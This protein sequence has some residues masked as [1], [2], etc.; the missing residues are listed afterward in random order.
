MLLFIRNA[1]IHTMDDH[2][3]LAS[4]ALVEDGRFVFVGSERGAQVELARRGPADETVDMEGRLV[5]PGFNDSH[6][7]FIHFA[8]S[9]RSVS[10]TGVC[11]IQEIQ[12]RMAQAVAARDPQNPT[13]LEGEGWNQ[14]YFT[15]GE[16][17]FPTR[18]DLDAVSPDVPMMIMRACFHIGVL[19]SAA[20]RAIGLNRE[21]APQYGDLVGVD[22]NGEPDG[23][24]KES[25]LDDTK[26]VISSLTLDSMKQIIVAAQQKALAQGITSL[27]SDD[28]GYTPKADYHLLFQAFGELEREG[29]LHIRVAEQ[30]LLQKTHL[31]Q[32][33]FADGYDDQWGTA[34]F[35][36]S[37]IKLLSD[38][39][40]GARTAAMRQ[41][42]ADGDTQGLT[43]FTQPELN[44][45]VLTA[46]RHNMPV[47]IHAIGD[48]AIEMSLDA[49][50]NAQLQ[51]PANRPR[52]GIVHCQITD[53]ALLERFR[54]LDVLAFVQ[55]IFIDYDMHICE[56][57]IGPALTSTSY[58]WR[59]LYESGVHTSFGTDC[60]VETFDT[61]PNL[62]TA[63]TRQNVT[64][65]G[66]Q[67]FLPG[68]A[69]TMEQ[70]LK[71]YT[72]E[73]AYASGEEGQKGTITPGKLADFIVL[74]R[75]LFQIDPEEILQTKVLQT[76][77]QGQ[78][79]YTVAP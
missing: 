32:Q 1:N 23:I 4:A 66:K 19:N 24:I 47:A 62:Y 37:C 73:G 61:M 57:R 13:W 21:T 79:C 74:D 12:Q 39:S 34:F 18:A 60:P 14:D 68:Q 49:I 78:L 9:L 10:L 65:Q 55:P 8:K 38:G 6:M 70:A 46:H 50:E 43:M 11:S 30:C 22:A 64:G 2:R 33:F 71:C 41:P 56:D 54:K 51:C 76:W 77:V 35:R 45:L 26:A 29:K 31:I 48:K 5:L 52:H 25:F 58:A 16:K 27:Q 17:R 42:Y 20:L 75:D 67:R 36:P 28:V 69:M 59:T 40:L 63:V 7:H 53:P 72:I 44:E 15:E 3:P